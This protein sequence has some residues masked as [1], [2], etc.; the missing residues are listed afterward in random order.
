MDFIEL[1]LAPIYKLLSVLSGMSLDSPDFLSKLAVT[2]SSENAIESTMR[3]GDQLYMHA[4]LSI[5]LAESFIQRN[6]IR[7]AEILQNYSQVFPILDSS[8]M[9]PHLFESY[10]FGGLVAFRIARE[11]GEPYWMEKGTEILN[12]FENL[13]T[14]CEWNFENKYFLLKAELLHV[15][16]ETK[17]AIEAYDKAVE[18]A[19]KHRFIHQEAIAC[20]L[21]AHFFGNIGAKQRMREMIQKS[22]NLYVEWGAK[23]KAESVIKLLELQY[24]QEPS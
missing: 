20:E 12:S 8:R 18:S 1:Y 10:F 7:A 14:R 2:I 24:L 17:T 15:K 23:K 4:V 11:T 19:R 5:C 22:H 16:K 6:F 13:S 21:A 9:R 3:K